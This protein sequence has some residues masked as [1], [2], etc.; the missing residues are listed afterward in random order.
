MCGASTSICS[1]GPDCREHAPWHCASAEL[2]TLKRAYE[3]FA[4]HVSPFSEKPACA[5]PQSLI[6]TVVDQQCR[7]LVPPLAQEEQDFLHATVGQQCRAL[8]GGIFHTV[9]GVLRRILLRDDW[10]A[11]EVQGKG[12]FPL[13]KLN[14]IQLETMWTSFGATLVFELQ[15]GGGE[16]VPRPPLQF[17]FKQFDVRIR[18]VLTT[19]V[20][21]NVAKRL[22]QQTTRRGSRLPSRK[23]LQVA[24]RGAPRQLEE[25]GNSMEGGRASP[26]RSSERFQPLQHGSD[27]VRP[28]QDSVREHRTPPPPHGSAAALTPG[29]LARLRDLKSM[30][31]LNGKLAVCERL[32]TSTGRWHVCL[33]DSREVK[34]VKP[35]NLAAVPAGQEEALCVVCLCAP[36]TMAF[37][38]CGHR[39]LCGGC[40]GRLEGDLR[41]RCAQC[42]QPS[43][44]IIRIFC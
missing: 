37:V 36:A 3:A 29:A 27:E 43:S 7:L 34:S 10:T 2:K 23:G 24:Q 30:P 25:R 33:C 22:Q 20:L 9:D 28:E 14:S 26:S 18:F 19:K 35:E 15:T 5:E 32:D 12:L 21:R 8:A 31:Q 17:R 1:V 39:C 41:R 6:R 44:S 16:E 4:M 13:H 40:A 11:I 42:R 38:P